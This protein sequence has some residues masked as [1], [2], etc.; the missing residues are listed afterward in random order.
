M[1]AI[2]EVG[3]V[4]VKAEVPNAAAVRTAAAAAVEYAL[5][6]VDVVVFVMAG[7]VA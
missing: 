3:I 4:A 5:V 2:V 7:V 1:L 6:S